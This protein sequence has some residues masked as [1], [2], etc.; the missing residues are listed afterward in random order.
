[1]SKKKATKPALVK[2]TLAPDRVLGFAGAVRSPRSSRTPAGDQRLTINL[3]QDLHFRLKFA[4]LKQ[5]TTCGELIEK[6]IETH[7]PAL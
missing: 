2:P 1:M 3:R 7:C 6:L 4:A 5:G